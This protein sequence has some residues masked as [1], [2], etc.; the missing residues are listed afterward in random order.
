MLPQPIDWREA[1]LSSVVA[2][3]RRL[4]WIS[5]AWASQMALRGFE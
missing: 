1:I 5:A 4:G 2:A 3:P